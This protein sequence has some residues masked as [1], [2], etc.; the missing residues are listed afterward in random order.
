MLKRRTVLKW[1]SRS[2]IVLAVIA[3]LLLLGIDRWRAYRLAEFQPRVHDALARVDA[4]ILKGKTPAEWQAVRAAQ[5]GGRNGWEHIAFIEDLYEADS[6]WH[7][8][9]KY[10]PDGPVPESVTTWL[11]VE[12]LRDYLD[13]HWAGGEHE[14]WQHEEGDGT[15]LIPPPEVLEQ[16][17]RET[18]ALADGFAKAA[19]ADCVVKL[20][21]EDALY[22]D[23]DGIAVIPRLAS[24]NAMLGRCK[25]LGALGRH[26]QAW[27]EL[28]A[29]VQAL[30]KHSAP[31]TIVDFMLVYSCHGAAAEFAHKHLLDGTLTPAAARRL[32]RWALLDRDRLID[33]IEGETVWLATLV[34]QA[35]YVTTPPAWFDWLTDDLPPGEGMF[36]IRDDDSSLQSR[37]AGP[38]NMTRECAIALE[39][40]LAT[41]AY[42]RGPNAWRLA[43]VPQQEESLFAIP[44][45][46]ILRRGDVT[47]TAARWLE[48]ELRV[49][50]L[51]GGALIDQ[52]AA[53]A[54]A[55]SR[56]PGLE[57][58]FDG[59]DVRVRLSGQLRDDYRAVALVSGNDERIIEPAE[60]ARNSSRED[61]WD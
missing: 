58:D 36:I 39:A 3:L 16:W 28:E 10:S 51:E 29:Y 55:V 52:R 40:N 47:L 56:Y 21:R 22:P 46:A 49:I 6:K 57:H 12:A 26:D 53:V 14:L 43:E 1:I 20:A 24:Y 27:N 33:A 5:A 42:A 8:S 37:W 15:A 34:R 11:A 45:G 60:Q 17:L 7:Q 44:Q 2:V 59:K 41:L 61:G 18:Q 13:D 23:A 19:T 4:E 54:E 25:A 9:D 35:G 31:T 38:I 50:E 30:S 48:L 32:L